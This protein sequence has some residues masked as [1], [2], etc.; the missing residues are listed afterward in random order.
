MNVSITTY[1]INHVAIND[2][3]SVAVLS[4]PTFSVKSSWISMWSRATE[5]NKMQ[6]RFKRSIEWRSATHPIALIRAVRC[7]SY[8]TERR[9]FAALF[10]PYSTY[11]NTKRRTKQTVYTLFWRATEFNRSIIGIMLI[12]TWMMLHRKHFHFTCWRRNI[13]SEQLIIHRPNMTQ[14]FGASYGLDNLN[15][16]Y[17]QVRLFVSLRIYDQF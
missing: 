15:T 13:L 5:S 7:V 11:T 3:T 16:Q 12:L 1:R 4:P 8:L 17:K 9:V 2:G 10:L 14:N 6:K